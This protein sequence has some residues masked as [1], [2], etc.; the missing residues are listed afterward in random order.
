MGII[1]LYYIIYSSVLIILGFWSISTIYLIL[2]VFNYSNKVFYSN[3]FHTTEHATR[4]YWLKCWFC[5][6]C[7]FGMVF[8]LV[9]SFLSFSL[10]LLPSFT[11]TKSFRSTKQRFA[12]KCFEKRSILV[13]LVTSLVITFPSPF[14]LNLFSKNKITIKH[15]YLWHLPSVDDTLILGIQR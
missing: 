2:S 4:F 8:W 3:L 11:S 5:R 6:C 14:F 13:F 15:M 12:C 7:N 1:W 10:S 9:S